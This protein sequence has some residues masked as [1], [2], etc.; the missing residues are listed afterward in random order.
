MKA[1]DPI[2]LCLAGRISPQVALAR[3]ALQG[4]SA[5][6]I[7]ARRS[8]L[9]VPDAAPLR[10]LLR[11]RRAAID[12]MAALQVD[13]TR[14]GASGAEAIAYVAAEFDQA[15]ARAPEI[16]AASCSLGDPSTLA[17]ITEEIVVWLARMHVLRPG[18]VVLDLGCG[19]GRVAAS[20][21]AR[22]CS[23][24]GLDISSAMIAEARR[25]YPHMRFAVTPGTGLAFLA[26]GSFDLVLAVDSFPYL[27]QEGVAERPVK[28]TARCLRPDGALAIF[29]LS[30]RDDPAADEKDARRWA[31][32]YGL[33]LAVNGEAPFTLWDGRAFVFRVPP[34]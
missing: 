3:L 21:A 5:S 18:N 14:A 25:R 10:Q 13:H 22:G 17:R 16:S 23:V 2:A 11:Q 20:L 19:F 32:Q 34:S 31:A 12:G 8:R 29:N 26:D 1:S 24:L 4:A 28:D 9:R 6:E 27:V 30:Y 7:E 33:L 15:V